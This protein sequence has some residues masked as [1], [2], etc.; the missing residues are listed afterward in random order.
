MIRLTL[1][2][3]SRSRSSSDAV[4]IHN[5]QLLS[6]PTMQ[7]YRLS[8]VR[9]QH[10][11]A[12]S[13]LGV[14]TQIEARTVWCSPVLL[15]QDSIVSCDMSS[16]KP[17]MRAIRCQMI[18]FVHVMGGSQTDRYRYGVASLTSSTLYEP[19]I[20]APTNDE[21]NINPSD[22]GNKRREMMVWSC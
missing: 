22:F 14:A 13:R 10:L 9:I 3:C 17:P 20:P 2:K 7:Y 6:L 8:H 11:T 4:S 1:K 12:T 21:A 16:R 18:L 5:F 15:E 19:S